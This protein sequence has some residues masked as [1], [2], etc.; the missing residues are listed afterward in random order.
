MAN[1]P[2]S[3]RT[4]LEHYSCPE[5]NTGCWLWVGATSRGYGTTSVLGKMVRAHR[6]SWLLH[7]GPIAEGAWVLHK[8]DTP[9]C[10]NPDHLYLGTHQDN[11]TDM[12]RKGRAKGK[13]KNVGARN[14]N[15]RL[16]DEN[17]TEIRASRESHATLASRFGV[18]HTTIRNIRAGESWKHVA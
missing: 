4:R 15:S 14:P 17:I 2:P 9:L 8:C 13:R 3:L 12:R 1:K 16:T 18:A 5:P 10:I 7:H 11:M 6:A